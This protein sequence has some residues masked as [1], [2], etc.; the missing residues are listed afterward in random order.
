MPVKEASAPAQ[1]QDVSRME[2][3]MNTNVDAVFNLIL[4]VLPSFC[5]CW[6]QSNPLHLS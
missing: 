6:Y 1:V 5:R 2:W 3:G 4:Q